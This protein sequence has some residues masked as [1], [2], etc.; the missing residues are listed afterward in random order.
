MI[1]GT[2]LLACIAGAGLLFVRRPLAAA[3]LF[4]LLLLIG[5]F[6]GPMALGGS[7]I[8]VLVLWAVPMAI[9]GPTPL[10]RA[11]ITPRVFKMV[12]PILPV[13]SQTEKDA[14]DAGTVWW[15]GELFSGSP[16]WKQLFAFKPRDLTE[17]EEA[18]LKGPVNRVCS[19]VTDWEVNQA[20]DLPAE[21]WAFLKQE[22]FLGMI[23]P[24][25]YGGKGFSAYGHSAVIARLS[26]RSTVLAVSV[27]VPNSL[28]PAEL[29]LH[30]GTEEQKDH[31]LPRLADGRDVPAFALTEPSAGSDAAGMTSRGVVCR[32]E[33][34]GEEVLGMMLNWDKRYITL[35]AIA[36][37]LGLAFK[38]DDPDGLLGNKPHY[39][40]TVALVPTDLPGIDCGERHD[41]LGIPFFNGP[42]RGK[43][44]FVPLDFIVGGAKNAGKGWRMLM[45]SLAAGRGISLPSLS[46]G[47]AQL[48]TRT[49]GAY[50]SVRRQFGMPI[51]RFEGIEE[52]MARIA[53]STYWLDAVRRLTVGAIDAG[54]KPAVLTAICK[55][56]MTESMRDAV[57]DGM[58]VVGG[59]GIVR[60]PRNIM[61][62][63]YVGAPISITVEGAN[64]LTRSMI[65]FGQGAIRCHPFAQK[66]IDAA[67]RKNLGEFDR[68]FFGHVGF[69]FQNASR[70]TLLA[71]SG[72]HLA[73]SPVHGPTSYYVKQLTRLSA[74][75]ALTADVA[76][77]TLGGG[78]KRMEKLTGR[79]ADVLAW[80]YIGS[81]VV[82]RFRHE[83]R[84]ER[85]LPY[86]RWAAQTALFE[87]EQ[88]LYGVLRNLPMRPIGTMLKLAVFPLG[89]RLAPPSDRLGGKVAK[90][91]LFDGEARTSLTGDVYLPHGDEPGLGRLETALAA[92][93]VARP[94][95]KRINDAAREKKLERKPV[96]TLPDRALAL[97]LIT[98]EER[99]LLAHAAAE[100][101]D[102][103]QVD[104]FE[105]DDYLKMRR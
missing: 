39:G 68:A 56:W 51:G 91:L 80:M 7:W 89:P 31:Y 64:I 55:R 28:G 99:E 15:D 57:T 86:M 53:G 1:L 20:G 72:G 82:H 60:G 11:L 41:P 52:P 78:L 71:F 3:M 61:S 49:V 38:L 29:L 81:A 32:G 33:W 46:C 87:A 96:A 16:N 6:G 69:V 100:R 27:M 83:G 45:D 47:G 77:G 75:F 84:Q 95:Q 105:L 62:A 34:E 44:V 24:K 59:S 73:S 93:N 25:E 58:D 94:I 10:R 21:V 18:F 90:G 30:Y 50:G 23:I 67:G 5:L 103:V 85:D 40:I 65:V 2:L 42:T 4:W 92:V 54:E 76:M 98:P 8:W 104:A 12:A 63:G 88:A 22:G 43:D 9:F 17:E 13:M 70:A 97:G 102:I 37:V 66:E 101:E 74:A 26:T 79:L 35:A 36:S 14:L 19:M 48:A